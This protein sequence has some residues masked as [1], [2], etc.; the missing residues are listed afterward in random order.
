VYALPF[1]CACAFFN[2]Y[3]D[4]AGGGEPEEAV[5]CVHTKFSRRMRVFLINMV[6]AQAE[7]SLKRLYGAEYCSQQETLL[8]REEQHLK[9]EQLKFAV[10]LFSFLQ[11]YVEK[12]LIL[13]LFTSD[14]TL[15]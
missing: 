6:T 10:L 9:E 8:I 4:C 12:L 5:R 3:G 13:P 14:Y 7:E 15:I 11:V 2:Q 1:Q